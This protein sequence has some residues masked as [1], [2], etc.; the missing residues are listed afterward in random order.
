MIR[1]WTTSNLATKS[2][3]FL[4]IMR[5]RRLS[6]V[7]YRFLT[8]TKP[9][10]HWGNDFWN[11]AKSSISFLWFDNWLSFSELEVYII[12]VKKVDSGRP[13]FIDDFG[14]IQRSLGVEGTL[15]EEQC[16]CWNWSTG[17]IRISFFLLF[18]RFSR[19]FWAR[20]LHICRQWHWGL[21]LR[22]VISL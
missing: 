22:V 19:E 14:F 16:V 11:F 12:L 10:P 8:F 6:Y 2:L 4:M 9:I 20:S 18:G 1:D 13:R 21:L 3:Y 17:L 7:T 15:P 5:A